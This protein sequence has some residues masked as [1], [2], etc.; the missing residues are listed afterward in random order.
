MSD[1]PYRLTDDLVT[2]AL[3]ARSAD[4]DLALLEDIVRTAAATPQ[5]RR[6]P[7]LGSTSLSRP[8][9]LVIALA[10]L[11][12][13]AGALAVGSGLLPPDPVPAEQLTVAGQIIEAANTRDPESLR[14]LMAE[15]GVLEFP[16]VDAR[17]G[18]EGEVYM[19][20]YAMAVEKFPEAWVGNL[21]RWG[22]EAHLGSCQAVAESTITC[23]VTTRWHTLQI[24]I[25]EDWTFE[26]DGARVS[27]LEMLRVD[28]DPPNRLL[29]LGLVDLPTWEAWLRETHPSQADSL[30]PSGPDFFGWMYFRF[31]LDASPDE[32]GAS[33]DEYLAARSVVE[34]PTPTPSLTS[35]GTPVELPSSGSLDAGTY[36][37]VNPYQDDDPVRD[38]ASGCADYRRVVFTLPDG[39]A[40]SGGLVHKHLGQPDEVAFGLWTPGQIYADPCHWEESALEPLDIH[41]ASGEPHLGM[42]D[43]AALLNQVGRTASEPTTVAFAEAGAGGRPEGVG[44]LKIELTVDPQLDLASCDRGEFRSWTEWDVPDGANSHHAPGQVDVV[45][46]VDVDRRTFVIDASQMPAASET[47]LAELEAIISSMIVVR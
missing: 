1:N 16:W 34:S 29:P 47:D 13:T 42:D 7:G 23:A 4:P 5:L 43:Q 30:L 28:P 32:I 31:G 39:W 46:L 26:F 37:L 9:V 2:Q 15:D 3:R 33:I 22:M 45:Y 19:S 38:C 36:F 20:E 6:W 27:R 21:D 18:R 25:G 12:A 41:T 44:A 11:L 40:T 14:S 24:E 8:A 17:A 35:D 10:L